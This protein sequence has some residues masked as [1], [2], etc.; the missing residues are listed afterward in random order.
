MIWVSGNSRRAPAYYLIA[1]SRP[2]QEIAS[3]EILDQMQIGVAEI[4]LSTRSQRP[5]AEVAAYREAL[6]RNKKRQRS[7]PRYFQYQNCK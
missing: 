4:E 3:P 7:Q 5:D 2:L 1:A 6:I